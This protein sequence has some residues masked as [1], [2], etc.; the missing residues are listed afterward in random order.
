MNKTVREYNEE[1]QAQK[2]RTNN[3]MKTFLQ[4]VQNQAYA[5]ANL[6]VARLLTGMN[7]G[8]QYMYGSS[9]VTE[10]IEPI[11]PDM[12]GNPAVY[13]PSE[14]RVALKN[15]SGKITTRVVD[16]RKIVEYVNPEGFT[17][18]DFEI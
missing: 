10:I 11:Y 13:V 7:N 16:V 17:E 14:A 2:I 8:K 9:I 5:Y 12:P 3:A 1:Y 18:D 6:T 4:E 15:K